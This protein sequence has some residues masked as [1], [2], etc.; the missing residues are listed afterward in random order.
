MTLWSAVSDAPAVTTGSE[1]MIN[2]Q[3][4]MIRSATRDTTRITGESKFK[5]FTIISFL[6]GLPRPAAAF[7]RSPGRGGVLGTTLFF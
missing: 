5:K 6:P 7:S 4:R 1:Q 2:S 3:L